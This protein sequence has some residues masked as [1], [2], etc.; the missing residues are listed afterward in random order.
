MYISLQST[1][2]MKWRFF[3]ILNQLDTLE[4]FPR[5]YSC[6]QE[7]IKL[8]PDAQFPSPQEEMRSTTSSD[9]SLAQ[10]ERPQ[11][12]Q[13]SFNRQLKNPHK[14]HPEDKQQDFM[15]HKCFCFC[16]IKEL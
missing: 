2:T 3:F 14:F 1:E 11:V 8:P 10:G 12:S 5:K 4:N 13:F 15:E 6:L 16:N 7:R 9:S